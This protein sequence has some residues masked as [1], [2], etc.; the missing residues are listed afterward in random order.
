MLF[1][2]L[3]VALYFTMVYHPQS[4]GQS[5]RTNQTVE[6]MVHHISQADPMVNWEDK[7]PII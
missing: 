6:L 2:L 4:D 7:L 5:E 3:T 1:I